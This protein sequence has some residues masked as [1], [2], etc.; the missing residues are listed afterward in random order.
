M[1]KQTIGLNG[2]QFKENI[3]LFNFVAL[4]FCVFYTINYWLDYNWYAIGVILIPMFYL[5]RYGLK[6]S[7]ADDYFKYLLLLLLFVVFI[8]LIYQLSYY[9]K[10]RVFGYTFIISNIILLILVFLDY[11]SLKEN[12]VL[13]IFYD[14]IDKAIVE[15]TDAFGFEKTYLDFSK[16][17]ESRYKLK[18]FDGNILF[19]IIT[20]PIVVLCLVLAPFSK[21]I[22]VISG[23]LFSKNGGDYDF[24]IL[25][26]TFAL[27]VIL[28]KS[29]CAFYSGFLYFKSK[30]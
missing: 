26:L 4:M 18:W 11:F 8:N 22:P 27:N 1:E 5:W 6:I 3:K 23:Y 16:Y 19:S 7:K 28:F 10:Y 2:L 12:G 9:F 30:K 29:S 24:I 25:I 14:G 15:V 17:Q 21:S 20:I 13:S